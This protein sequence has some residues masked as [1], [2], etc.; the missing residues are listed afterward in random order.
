MFGSEDHTHPEWAIISIN[1]ADVFQRNCTTGDYWQW[2]VSDG[3]CVIRLSDFRREW[4]CIAICATHFKEAH[5]DKGSH[6]LAGLMRQ[7]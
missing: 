3:V 4:G 6:V 2:P 5:V 1:F 7:D